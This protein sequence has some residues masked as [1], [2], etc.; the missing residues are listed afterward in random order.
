MSPLIETVVWPFQAIWLQGQGVGEGRGKRLADLWHSHHKP[1]VE[2]FGL[3][4][5]HRDM[6][7]WRCYTSGFDCS[8]A[9]VVLGFEEGCLHLRFRASHLGGC[10]LAVDFALE[11]AR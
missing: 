2:V 4:A 8:L 11:A 6:R 3:L 9:V 1:A 7:C 5:A 10:L